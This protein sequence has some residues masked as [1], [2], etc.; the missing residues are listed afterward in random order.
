M[1]K[2]IV[3]FSVIASSAISFFC[4]ASSCPYSRDSTIISFRGGG[5][6]SGSGSSNTAAFSSM[7]HSTE[8]EPH[9]QLP[10]NINHNSDETSGEIPFNKNQKALILMDSFT[11]YHGGYLSHQAKKL[12]NVTIIHVLSN[13][14]SGYLLQQLNQNDDDDKEDEL[15]NILSTKVP[16]H[17]SSGI[18]SNDYSTYDPQQSL[19]LADITQE[20]FIQTKY[21]KDK[22]SFL[23]IVGIICESDSGLEDAERLGIALGLYPHRHDGYNRK[24]NMFTH[25]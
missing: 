11:P 23:N 18:S 3:I 6:G 15:Y 20:D 17:P 21:W 10:Y 1:K 12:Y 8:L 13:Y 22:I 25:S 9:Y 19:L 16:I 24:K 14:M 5:S 7:M 2:H 4:D